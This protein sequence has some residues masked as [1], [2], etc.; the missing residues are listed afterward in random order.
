MRLLMYTWAIFVLA[1]KR[2]MAQRGLALATIVGLTI[3]IALTMSIP[4][5]ADAIYLN[6]FHQN[7]Y[8][9]NNGQTEENS[10]YPPLSF[11]FSYDGSSYGSKAWNDLQPITQYFSEQ[12]S[13]SFGLPRNLYEQYLVTNSYGL[14]PL[15]NNN[16]QIESQQR[17]SW[18]SFALVSD[19]QKHITLV[20]GTFPAARTSSEDHIAEV[21]VS[22]SFVQK[23]GLHVGEEY[24][25]Y[26]KSGNNANLEANIENRV[27]IAGVWRPT[28]PNEPYWFL[29]PDFLKDRLLVSEEV[30]NQAINPALTNNI[31]IAF[32]YFVLDDAHVHYQ[33]TD[34]LL[35]QISYI[36]Q[37]ARTLLPN[38]KL[39]VS[40]VDKLLTYKQRSVQLTFQLL[41][42]SLPVL[43]LLFAFIYLA[44]NLAIDQR[45][46]EISILRSRGAGLVQTTLIGFIETVIL[47]IL[48]LLISLPISLIITQWIGKTRQFMQFDPGF[49]LSVSVTNLGLRF[50]LSAGI[51]G[52]LFQI[53]PTINAAR[54]TIISYKQERSRVL[55][56]PWWQRFGLDILLFIPAIYAIYLLRQG[57]II[58]Q[59]PIENPL[60]L[61]LPLFLIFSA[62]LFTIRIMPLIMGGIAW[63]AAR[64]QSVG[65]LMAARHL[66]R[67]PHFYAIPFALLTLTLSLSSFFASLAL[68]LDQNLHDQIYYNVGSD[69]ELLDT[70]EV[71]REGPPLMGVES[72]Q[73]GNSAN[74]GSPWIFLPVSEYQNL[75][76]VQSV[77]R[78]GRYTATA[79][80]GEGTETGVFLGVDRVGF[81]RVAYWR[82][83]F[84]T[85]SL[86]ALMN[87]LASVRN[88]VLLARDVMRQHSLKLGDK[89]YLTVNTYGQNN[90]VEL[91]IVGEFDAFPTWCPGQGPLFVGNLN[92]L[93]LKAGGQFPYQVW[94]KVDPSSNMVQ[95]VD[96]ATQLSNSMALNW[97]AALPQISAEQERPDRQGIFGI[98]SVGFIATILLTV[99]GFLLYALFSFQRRYVEFGVLRAIGLSTTQMIS[100]LASELAFL[101]LFGAG[102]GTGLGIAVSKFFIPYLHIFTNASE[103]TPGFIVKIAWTDIFR[104][105][106]LFGML[107]VLALFIMVMLLRKM[108]LFQAIK[109]GETT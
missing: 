65:L 56:K 102:I 79:S 99:L 46:N 54:H 31:Y 47:V 105:Y 62:T 44:A 18:V 69:L 42:F 61:L 45:R 14:Y 109:L 27:R 6:L 81:S 67:T 43:A 3:T 107:F 60:F 2:I 77:A 76:G 89:V 48:S 37:H 94:M 22:E 101:V 93:F 83:D 8:T 91:Q 30:F 97:E 38:V 108:K 20:E 78:V 4:L 10:H 90:R 86:G 16:N 36:Q 53:L 25:V 58:P 64:T 34:A 106:G 66:A 100:F 74:S 1:I 17:L 92:D 33:M 51:S 41:A 68:T 13:L 63:I 19:I 103:C 29:S 73:N 15:D 98:L 49:R 24:L 35:S 26:G 12:A 40:P 80:W 88:S 75:Q 9:D 23:M 28:N 104:I 7:I 11:L 39:Q 71:V 70:G 50:G 21:M 72:E 52:I 84:S 95:V 5:Y 96:Q 82:E 55:Q 32:W 85:D 57:E 59:N 87:R